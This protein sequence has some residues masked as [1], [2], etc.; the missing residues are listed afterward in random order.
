MLRLPW[1][2]GLVPLASLLALCA[3]ALYWAA[4]AL[5]VGLMWASLVLLVDLVLLR[6]LRLVRRAPHALREATAALVAALVPAYEDARALRS[7]IARLEKR[8]KRTEQHLKQQ[9]KALHQLQQQQRGHHHQ[10]PSSPSHD[11]RR[12]VAEARQ[13]QFEGVRVALPPAPPVAAAPLPP[14]PPPPTMPR[15][16][17]VIIKSKAGVQSSVLAKARAGGVPTPA[18]TLQDLMRV[19]L[20]PTTK[21]SDVVVDEEAC[22]SNSSFSGGSSR[23]APRG[24]SVSLADITNVQLRRSAARQPAHGAGAR[25]SPLKVPAGFQLKRVQG[26]ERS[27]GGTPI[28]P[29]IVKSSHNNTVDKFAIALKKKF[30]SSLISSP[31]RSAHASPA[32]SPMA[33]GTPISLNASFAR[34]PN[35]LSACLSP[36]ASFLDSSVISPIRAD[37]L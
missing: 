11:E 14:P 36:L 12:H 4:R 16:P 6:P 34:S 10:L 20:K 5:L 15:A 31:P 22:G 13:Q 1:D 37:K 32:C 25:G 8:L 7:A 17:L 23:K 33:P 2:Y 35:N 9:N 24:L 28:R 3:R 21:L 30:E 27:P 26:I 18:V 19:K 29:D